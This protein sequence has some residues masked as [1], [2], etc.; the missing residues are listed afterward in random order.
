MCGRDCRQTAAKP[1]VSQIRDIIMER[2][3]RTR[4]KRKRQNGLTTFFEHGVAL[5]GDV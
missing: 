5:V 3:L 2:D 4:A 1:N